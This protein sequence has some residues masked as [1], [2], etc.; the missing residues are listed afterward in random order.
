MSDVINSSTRRLK[1]ITFIQSKRY[2]TVNEIADEFGISRRTVF[3]YINVLTEMGIPLASDRD[4]G[5]SIN[6]SHTMP[7]FV[8]TEKELSTL[9]V[10]LGYLKGQVDHGL[11][12]SARDVEL[13]ILS[14]LNNDQKSYIRSISQS[15][16]LYP[17]HHEE[18]WA[19][20]NESWYD[21]LTAINKRNT[22]SCTYLSLAQNKVSERIIDP[23]LLVYYT[24]HWDLIGRCHESNSLRTFVLGRISN[25]SVDY[26]SYFT[27]DGLGN[28]DIIHRNRENYQSIHIRVDNKDVDTLLRSLPAIIETV[29][30][31]EAY[32]D[33][34]FGFDNLR[35]MN[36][37]LL[38]FGSSV[39][40]IEPSDMIEDRKSLLMELLT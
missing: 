15:I 5:Y 34:R 13:M 37:W 6:N 31:R 3:R 32:T 11:S 9:M 39:T 4:R 8:F 27:R 36:Q 40:I 25:L 17:Y 14:K 20:T 35:W 12:Q 18:V 38:Q 33:V 28:E 22:I 26:K 16:I 21:L 19:K 30:K 2:V 29:D 1:L 10:G 23:Y 7:P 24:D